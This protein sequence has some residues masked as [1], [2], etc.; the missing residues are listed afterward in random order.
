MKQFLKLKLLMGL[1]AIFVAGSVSGGFVGARIQKESSHDLSK[2]EKFKDH[3]LEYLT[4]ELSLRPDQVAKI[5]PMI[6]DATEEFRVI[7]RESAARVEKVIRKYHYKISDELDP[8]QVKIIKELERK[9]RL[10]APGSL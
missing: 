10:K 4:T 8:D 1:V 7:H 6:A 2:M 3:I 5:E 9:R